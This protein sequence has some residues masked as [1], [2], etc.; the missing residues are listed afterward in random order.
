MLV[1]LSVIIALISV[2]W[3]FWRLDS[4]KDLVGVWGW[5]LN[6]FITAMLFSASTMLMLLAITDIA[7]TIWV[8]VTIIGFFALCID[9]S[10]TA[11]RFHLEDLPPDQQ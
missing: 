8:S 10:Y 9:A 3:H 7:A 6:V 4:Y 11:I 1:L 5:V 2:V